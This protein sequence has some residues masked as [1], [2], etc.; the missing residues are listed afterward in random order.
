MCE[1]LQSER[2][3]S[4]ARAS[5]LYLTDC[6]FDHVVFTDEEKFQIPGRVNRHNCVIY[7]SESPR[8]QSEHERAS[9]KVNVRFAMTYVRAI[10]QFLL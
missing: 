3:R 9:P 6:S 5:Q 1:M 7:G 4:S 8:E 2:V 10:G